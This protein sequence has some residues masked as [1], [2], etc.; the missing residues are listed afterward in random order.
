MK[1]DDAVMNIGT[2]PDLRRV[3]SA[4]VVYPPFDSA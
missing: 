4:H 2:V 3:A 1:F